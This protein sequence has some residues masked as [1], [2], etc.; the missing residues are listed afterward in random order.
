[1]TSPLSIRRSTNL[2]WMERCR[3]KR[4]P[5]M[6]VCPRRREDARDRTHDGGFKVGVLEHDI[7]RLAAQLEGDVLE[8]ASGGL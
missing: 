4:D 6:Q 8:V 2:S 3:S 1:M 7:R 5:A